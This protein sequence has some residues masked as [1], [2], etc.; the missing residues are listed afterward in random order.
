MILYVKNYKNIKYSINLMKLTRIEH[1]I[2]YIY[3]VKIHLYLLIE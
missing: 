2:R 1:G 3:I